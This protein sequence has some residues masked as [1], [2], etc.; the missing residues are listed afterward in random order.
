MCTLIDFYFET[1]IEES[2]VDKMRPEDFL[3]NV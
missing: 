1:F 3:L 2:K